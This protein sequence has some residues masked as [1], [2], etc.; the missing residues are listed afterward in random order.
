MRWRASRPH[1]GPVVR[2]SEVV[3]V[4]DTPLDVGVA[5]A[6]G[7]RSVGVATGSYDATRC[8]AAART[9]SLEDLSDLPAVLEA[10]GSVVIDG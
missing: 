5:V 8:G 6:G 4:G 9:S 2:P 3:I 1:G 10:L 7:A